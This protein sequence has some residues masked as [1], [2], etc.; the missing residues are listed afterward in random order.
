MRT[1]MK[2][3]L[4][5]KERMGCRSQFSRG[6]EM[7]CFIT[8][9]PSSRGTH[10][11]PAMTPTCQRRPLPAADGRPR[12]ASGLGRRSLRVCREAASAH[13]CANAGPRRRVG[14]QICR[15]QLRKTVRTSTIAVRAHAKACATPT[16]SPCR[17]VH[18]D[19]G[20]WLQP[21]RSPADRAPPRSRVLVFPEQC[22]PSRCRSRRRSAGWPSQRAPAAS[23]STRCS[24]RPARPRHRA[25]ARSPGPCSRGAGL[26]QRD[27]TASVEGERRAHKGAEREQSA[28]RAA[29]AT[30]SGAGRGG[31][32]VSRDA[33][34]GRP[35][36]AS[37]SAAWARR[38]RR[39]SS[40][41]GPHGPPPRSPTRA[42]AVRRASL[43]S[44]EGGREAL[45]EVAGAAATQHAQHHRAQRL[46]TQLVRRVRG[47]WTT[48]T[49]SDHTWGV[50]PG[51]SAEPRPPPGT[52]RRVSC[53]VRRLGTQL[54][55]KPPLL[56]RT[57]RRA[58]RRAARKQPVSS[59]ERS[60]SLCLQ[61]R[62]G[63]EV[64]A[65]EGETK[66]RQPSAACGR[67]D[68][69]DVEQSAARRTAEESER[70]GER[71]AQRWAVACTA[72][73]RPVL[74]DAV[75]AVEQDVPEV[76]QPHVRGEV[77]HDAEDEGRGEA[78]RQRHGVVGVLHPWRRARGGRVCGV[79]HRAALT[80]AHL[81]RVR[82]PP[83]ERP[84]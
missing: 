23:R 60:V 12:S 83:T 36:A 22:W 79:G 5:K 53:A 52:R 61:V 43:D 27:G 21:R 28:G 74:P 50:A 46:A 26:R 30:P 55:P 47:L 15:K 56:P 42:A 10:K 7:R 18:G 29:Q 66:G 38:L 57:P 35:V 39:Q 75:D 81:R 19:G 9:L 33:I 77:R 44:A 63:K 76:G 2:A 84:H 82:L 8:S 68:M 73:R 24:G 48:A 32:P 40:M 54:P 13:I 78:E 34:G 71:R 41:R 67:H 65:K 59:P 80:T 11:A 16:T 62:A 69:H 31:P 6:D 4:S 64:P 72:A 58:H 51:P 17:H 20:K 1:V 45:A 49:H 70:R 14:A 3:A 37:A 25:R